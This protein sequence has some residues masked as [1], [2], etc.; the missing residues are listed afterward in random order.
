MRNLWLVIKREYVTRVR[1]RAFILATLLTPLGFALFVVIVNAIFSYEN[2]EKQRIAVIDEGDLFNG[3]LADEAGLYFKLTDRPLEELRAENEESGDYSGILVVPPVEDPLKKQFKASYFS[4]AKL[5]L[6]LET[7]ISRKL[8]KAL[9]KYKITALEIDERQL[10]ALDTEVEIRSST[11]AAGAEEQ[12]TSFAGEIGAVIGTAM[13]FIM[14]ITVFVY[15]MM[16]MRSVME[17]KTNRIV[18]VVISSVKPFTLMLGKIIGV[19]AVGLTQ[20]IAWAI[21]I[22]G[23]LFIVALVFGFDPAAAQ[24]VPNAPDVDP[25]E[26]Q[27]MTERIISSLATLNWWVIVPAFFIYF[28]GGYFMYAALFAAVGSAMGDDLGEGQAL[29]IPITIPVILAFYIMIAALRAPNSSLAVW[30]SMIPLFSPIVMPARLPF[31]PPWW[32]V[33]VSLVIVIVFAIFLVWM[34]GRIYRIG[35][36]NYGKK[37]TFKD[38]GKWLFSND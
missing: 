18:E 9:R 3:A 37:G 10:K 28:L 30:S 2:D 36:L 21:L 6:D 13:G 31:D 33:V 23:L 14:Y 16:V 38:L 29:T 7:A 11:M 1:R 35:I 15:G 25:D 4:P 32:Q 27:A 26:I 34:S 17:E 12:D 5:T 8:E 19:G 24:E 22:P 20:V